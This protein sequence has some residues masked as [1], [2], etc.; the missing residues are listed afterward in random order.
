MDITAF[1]ENWAPTFF[2]TLFV[3][4]I[5]WLVRWV[6][7]RQSRNRQDS[8]VLSQIVLF[9]IL[10]VGFIAI[11]LAI[12]MG[13]SVKGQISG[14]IGI[15]ISAVLAL[16]S[17]T[18]IGNGLAG[19]MLRSI[20]NYK[21]GDFI[22]VGDILGRVSERGLFHTEIQT[23]NRDLITLPNLHLATNPVQVI[24]ASG[25][26]ISATVSLGYDVNHNKV[27]EILIRSAE[28]IGL[29][30][31]FVQVIELGDF[32]IVYKVFGLLT[33]AKTIISAQTRLY[34]SMLDELHD[35]RIE[36]V[37]PS[38]MNQ[39]QVNDALFIPKKAKKSEVTNQPDK[40]EEK[41]FDKAEQ[42]ESIEKR[43]ET[44]AEV[45][46]K[47]LDLTEVLKK[48]EDPLEKTEI[49]KRIDKWKGLKVKMEQKIETTI[50]EIS[51]KT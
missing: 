3:I 7:Q 42:A 47:I 48:S 22:R 24:R 40:V 39:R 38:F 8:K 5:Y 30:D 51:S 15:V 27:R 16:S 49:Q 26:F 18:F 25:T 1:L 28:K 29:K 2:T 36:I 11:I 43:K 46:A 34:C 33:D 20:N 9:S 17:A 12:P 50:D 45:N 32:S 44:I 23:E 35:G 13:E 4:F 41:I 10:I 6:L 37:S 21:P 19:I 31:A 14:L